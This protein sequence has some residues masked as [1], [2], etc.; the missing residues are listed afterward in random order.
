MALVSCQQMLDHELQ[1]VN[2]AILVQEFPPIHPFSPAR[3]L[4]AQATG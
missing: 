1:P 4:L 3:I 2:F